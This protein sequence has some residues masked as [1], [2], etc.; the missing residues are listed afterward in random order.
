[1]TLTDLE[2]YRQL[3][4]RH[5][6][7]IQMIEELRG[8]ANPGSPALDGM[9]H[10]SG[11]SDKVGTLAIMIADL[12]AK[13]PSY[14]RQIIKEHDQVEEFIRGIDDDKTRM[15]FRLRFQAGKTWKE[16]ADVMGKWQTENSVRSRVYRFLNLDANGNLED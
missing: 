5:E 8:R 11:V 3:K 7:A 16:V 12:E 14:E 9:P 1:M 4:I 10:G 13:L 6:E 2:R 15:I